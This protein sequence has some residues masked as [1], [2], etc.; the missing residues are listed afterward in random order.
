[1]RMI[2]MINTS[3]NAFTQRGHHAPEAELGR[4][5]RKLADLIV[6]GHQM[7]SFGN[8][9]INDSTGHPCGVIWWLQQAY[10]DDEI[11]GLIDE[12]GGPDD[13]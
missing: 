12:L 9:A 10:T 13:Y 4:I 2:L 7:Q 11:E 3:G 6:S 8:Q 1:M 5:L